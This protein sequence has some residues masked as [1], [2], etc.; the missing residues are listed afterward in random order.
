MGRTHWAA[1]LFARW[2]ELNQSGLT[3]GVADFVRADR[4]VMI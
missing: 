1:F 3:L 2:G 4:T